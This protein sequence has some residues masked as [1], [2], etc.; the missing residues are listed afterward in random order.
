MHMQLR[1]SARAR[2]SVDDGTRHSCDE[3]R[4]QEARFVHTEQQTSPDSFL[5]LNALCL[6]LRLPWLNY[7]VDVLKMLNAMIKDRENLKLKLSWW[8]P[9]KHG[10]LHTR[11][12]CAK[13][14]VAVCMLSSRLGKRKN[15]A[16]PQNQNLNINLH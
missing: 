1:T 11:E 4:P 3:L 10:Q 9:T 2:C 5:L 7:F 14:A 8:G 13:S 16:H 12:S 6:L 15:G